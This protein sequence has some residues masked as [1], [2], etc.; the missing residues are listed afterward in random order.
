MELGPVRVWPLPLRGP[1]RGPSVSLRS[2]GYGV[3]GETNLTER[4]SVRG[5]EVNGSCDATLA[6]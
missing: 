3:P 2:N 1:G 5:S 4:G 6:V